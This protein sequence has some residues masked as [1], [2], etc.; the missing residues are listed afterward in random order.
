MALALRRRPTRPTSRPARDF[1]CAF[2]DRDLRVVAQAFTQPVHL[3]SFV[4]LVPRAVR[5]LRARRLLPGDMLVT[6]DPYRGGVHLNDVTVIAPGPPRGR[7]RRLRRQP[8]P[9][10]RR[11]R[12][13]AG[14]DR[15]LPRGLPGGRD[16]PAG[17]AGRG[18]R[19]RR[20][21]LPAV[22]AQI[23]SKHETA[24]DFRAQVAANVT[25]MRRIAGSSSGTG[26]RRSLADDARSCST[27]PSGGPGRARRAAARH[28]RGRGRPRQRRL[29][30]RA[31]AACASRVD[32]RRRRRP[33]RPD[34][35]RP[36]APRAG[37]LDL[38]ADLLGLRLRA[39]VPDRS[40]TCRSTTASTGWS[41]S[42]RRRARSRTAR[43]RRRSS[44]A[45][46]RRRG[47]RRDLQGAAPALPDAVPAGTKAMMCQA[48]FGGVRPATRRVL[49]LLRDARRRLRRPAARATAR[50][51][52][53][54]TGR[55]PRTRRSRRPS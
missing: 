1:S 44:A 24:G 45:G 43:C 37:Q 22:L 33:L 53:R 18:R 10:R 35:L 29:H 42:S 23:R 48:G 3:G 34:W 39:Q 17:Q 50:T 54:R 27:T 31:G 14:L 28:L 26:A 7:A 41:A 2:F 36:A 4:E 13:R 21:R 9:P 6:N 49:L 16:H 47:Y 19:D 20:R 5:S 52:S 46:R 30:R 40:R 32:D 11:R 38:R 8:R 55:T 15:R 25:G 51:R 12:R